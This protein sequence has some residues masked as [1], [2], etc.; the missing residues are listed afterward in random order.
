M[1][2]SVLQFLVKSIKLHNC[3]PKNDIHRLSVYGEQCKETNSKEK[4]TV[5]QKKFKPSHTIIKVLIIRIQNV[6]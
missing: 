3:D 4:C 1:V 5:N 6:G 2:P